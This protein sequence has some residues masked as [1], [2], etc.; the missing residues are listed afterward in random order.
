MMKL[1]LCLF[2]FS[3]MRMIMDVVIPVE[4]ED[5]D[6]VEIADVINFSLRQGKFLAYFLRK[7]YSI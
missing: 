2:L 1:N 5:V 3:E 7:C 4:L 6:R